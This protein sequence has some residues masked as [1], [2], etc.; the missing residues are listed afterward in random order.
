MLAR[1]EKKVKAPFFKK[2]Y[3]SYS[4]PYNEF[5]KMLLRAKPVRLLQQHLAI[6]FTFFLI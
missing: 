5:N 2:E 4:E 3:K 1:L 6:V